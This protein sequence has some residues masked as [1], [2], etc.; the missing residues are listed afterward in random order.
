MTE[1]M[2]IEKATAELIEGFEAVFD[3]DWYYTTMNWDLSFNYPL[4]EE[5]LVSDEELDKAKEMLVHVFGEP[6]ETCGVKRSTLL[7]DNPEE[8]RDWWHMVYMLESYHKVR[9]ILD[10]M[11]EEKA[12]ELVDGK[13]LDFVR[14]FEVVFH[15]DWANTEVYL[16]MSMESVKSKEERLEWKRRFEEVFGNDDSD[17]T[18]L[19]P[20][21]NPS[22]Y[23][24][25][26]WKLIKAYYDYKGIE[27]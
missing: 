1:S 16:G 11:G 24:D 23:W 12:S 2:E 6:D 18:F 19:R 22:T 13:I 9:E 4:L 7:E 20:I 27:I 14:C 17:A 8:I 26:G 25:N 15:E 10:G 21:G 5:E 3:E